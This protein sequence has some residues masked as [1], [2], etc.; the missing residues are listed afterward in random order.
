[1]GSTDVSTCQ[2]ASLSSYEANR[3]GCVVR[4]PNGNGVLVFS[5]FS[6]TSTGTT[7][8]TAAGITVTPDP[9]GLGG[10]FNF[11]GFTNHPVTAGQTV[12][13]QIDYSYLIDPGPVTS[14]ADIGMDPPFGNSVIQ[15]FVCADSQLVQTEGGPACQIAGTA[16][17][18]E[19]VARG[20]RV[21][22][23]ACQIAETAV[24]DFCPQTLRV[25]DTNPPVS[26]TD[27]LEL[28]PQVLQFAQ[29]EDLITLTGGQT[30]GAGLD[31]MTATN[32]VIIPTA[33]PE[34][35]T[36]LLL[37]GGLPLLGVLRHRRNAG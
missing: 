11:S 29:I 10:G 34:P 2:T 20:A 1:M 22:T 30:L 37:A 8:L 24:N 15:E 35:T 5:N 26:W 31:S 14:G 25:D 16:E 19:D 13:Y 32:D 7:T 33:T 17:N 27:H 9:N 4:D 36:Y 28:N 21:V 3:S 12:S 6:F 18:D 23:S